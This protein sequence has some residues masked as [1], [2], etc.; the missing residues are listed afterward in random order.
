V[1]SNPKNLVARLDQ[2][3]ALLRGSKPEQALATIRELRSIA[4]F[5]PKSS[6]VEAIALLELGK[7]TEGMSSIERELKLRDHPDAYYVQSV[8]F[9]RLQDTTNAWRSLEM[10]LKQDLLVNSQVQLDNACRS[11]LS[12]ARTGKDYERLV[13]L[14]SE[15]A[16]RFPQ[17]QTVAQIL[18][19]AEKNAG[20]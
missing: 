16:V 13:E 10:V 5:Y 12:L 7:L 8:L 11:L 18:G 15:I 6:L 17:N 20:D 19:E 4:P 2:S 14:L 9:T 1:S 3:M